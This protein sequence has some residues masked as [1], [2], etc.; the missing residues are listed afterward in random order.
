M[1]HHS[2]NKIKFICI[3]WY[4]KSMP[5]MDIRYVVFSF[6]TVITVHCKKSTFPKTVISDRLHLTDF[7]DEILLLLAY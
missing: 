1:H 6:N 4:T 2:N 5:G 7:L 3:M